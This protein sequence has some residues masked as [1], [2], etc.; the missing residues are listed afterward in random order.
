MA[1]EAGHAD[2]TVSRDPR[3]AL[4]RVL[5]REGPRFDFFQAVRLIQ[6]CFPTAPRVG[7]QGPAHQE[8]VR[9]FQPDLPVVSASWPRLPD[10]Y[11]GSGCTLSS[12][13]AAGLAH[14][15][16]LERAVAE[17]QA[18]TWESLRRARASGRAQ[19][20]PDRSRAAAG[21]RP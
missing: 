21:E 16:S 11:H 13:V 17:A 7:F 2:S 5:L 3:R 8:R 12:G 1:A 18:F 4:L 6:A 9:S 10:S 19:L 15:H 20:L 14:G